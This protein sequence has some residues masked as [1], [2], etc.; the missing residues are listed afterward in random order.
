MSDAISFY[1]DFSSPY[2]YFAALQADDLA[3]RSGREVAW[4]A[5]MI[6][7]AFRASGNKPLVDQP[8][9][10]AY[11]RHDWERVA[12]LINAPY[13]MPDRF[14]VAS[15]APSRAFWWLAD[16]D[17]ALAQRFAKAVFHAY[18]A[19]GEDI[20]DLAL[21]V[22]LGRTVGIDPA[23]LEA[24][25]QDAVWKQRLKDETETAIEQGVFG[26]PFFVVD[27]EGFWGADRMA[28]VEDWAKRGGW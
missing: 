11:A 5:I 4:K 8:I 1:F 25:A 12:R 17:Q 9:K 16:R 21:V 2:A 22:Q 3:W 13:R 20:S 26:S 23:A 24:A 18:F 6:G 10:G 28:M 27:G 7:S 19:E 15:L 14:P